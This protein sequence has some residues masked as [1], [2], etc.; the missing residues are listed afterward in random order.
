MAGELAAGVDFS[1]ITGAVEQIAAA[2]CLANDQLAE[3]DTY[4]KTRQGKKVPP[5]SRDRLARVIAH[6]LGNTIETTCNE[7]GIDPE[8]R[9]AVLEQALPVCGIIGENM[10]PVV[11]KLLSLV[12]SRPH[13]SVI[14]NGVRGIIRN[15][16]SGPMRPV[17]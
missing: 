5:E 15:G 14:W 11:P 16:N 9:N 10:V 6:D 2:H 3:L 17:G 8:A 13:L 7:A 12:E 1:L 4:Y